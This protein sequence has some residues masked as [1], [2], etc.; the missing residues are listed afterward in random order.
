MSTKPTDADR[1][2]ALKEKLQKHETAI[3]ASPFYTRT[4]SV[5]RPLNFTHIRCLALGSPTQEFQALYQLA[6]LKLLVVEFDIPEAHIS[7]Y[8][9]AFSPAD[10]L[11]LTS[12]LQYLVESPEQYT[13]SLEIA[14]KTL[15]YM[16]HAPRSLTELILCQQKPCWFLAN[17]FSVTMGTLTKA[18][19]LEEYPTLATLVHLFEKKRKDSPELTD[20]SD[21]FAPVVLRRRRN[22]PRKNVYVEPELEYNHDTYFCDVTIERLE[23][24]F[25]AVWKDSFSDLAL[26]VIVPKPKTSVDGEN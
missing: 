17:D 19:F 11:F 8:D 23:T 4:V 12:E 25:D 24:D 18:R 7:L 20:T 26:N 13:P 6:Y 3:A 10:I 1:S 9:P 15:H 21:G 16:P 5:L 22:R 14:N 2:H